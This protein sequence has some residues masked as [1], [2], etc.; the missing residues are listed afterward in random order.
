MRYVPPVDVTA[1]AST[2]RKPSRSAISRA[3]ASS[4]RVRLAFSIRRR[5]SR[6]RDEG[7]TLTY[8]DW[9]RAADSAVLSDRSKTGSPV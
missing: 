2:R 7:T 5:L 9:L 1:G 6:M 8:R 3:V 4:V